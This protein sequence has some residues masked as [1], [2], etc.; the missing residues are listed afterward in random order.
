MYL[1]SPTGKTVRVVGRVGNSAHNFVN[2]RIETN[3]TSLGTQS[4]N[5]GTAP[6]SS[7]YGPSEDLQTMFDEPMKGT[8]IFRICDR[9]GGDAGTLNWARLYVQSSF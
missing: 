2:T 3:A 1:L 4:I 6:F 5:Q 8:W 7:V 9:A